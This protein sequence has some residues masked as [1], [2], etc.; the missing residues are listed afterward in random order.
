MV[1]PPIIDRLISHGSNTVRDLPFNQWQHSVLSSTIPHSQS[2][3]LS[4][5]AIGP[6]GPSSQAPLLLP[7]G[8]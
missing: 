7:A 4:P 3:G 8:S 5:A 1:K 6:H 2:Q